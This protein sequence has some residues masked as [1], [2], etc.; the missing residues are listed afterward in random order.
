MPI[1]AVLGC[2]WGDEGKGKIVDLLARQA[3]WVARFQGG[4]NAG[5]TVYVGSRRLVLHLVPTGILHP[6]VRCAIGNGVVLDPEALVEEI[7]YLE[8]CSISLR[9]RLRIS[10]FAHL[11]TPLCRAAETLSAQDTAIGTTRRGIGPAYM[12]KAARRGLRV[13]DLIDAAFL[14]EKLRTQWTA[15]T[16]T[17]GVTEEAFAAVAGGSFEAIAARLAAA[18]GALAPMVCDV[19]DLLLSEDDRGARILAEGAQG[20]WLD[21]DHGTYPFVTSSNTTI[22]GLCTG[23]GIPPHRIRKVYGVVKAYTTRVGLGPFPTE[24]TGPE[25]DRFRERAGEYG[26]T[27]QRPRRCGWYDAV[28]SRRSCRIN[29]VD[30]L[31][32]TKADVLDELETVRMAVSYRP[33]GGQPTA[34]SAAGSAGAF[35]WPG[36]RWLE[37]VEPEYQEFAGWRTGLGECKSWMQLPEAARSYLEA[38]SGETGVDLG[39]VSI[40][41]G[42]DQVVQVRS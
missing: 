19:T 12:D 22:G 35:P 32:V 18:A 30:E 5:H 26:A 15:M 3:D 7:R 39:C 1:Q 8:G 10:P 33:A 16:G 36:S 25:G 38:L 17:A 27:T 6:N 31:I 24:F 14:R 28:L 20:A 11:V 40:G 41:P 23:L 29:G 34:S 9:D 42:R 4:A 2:Q 37:R 13:E 21:L